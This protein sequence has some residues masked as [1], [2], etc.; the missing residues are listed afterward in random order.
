M[1]TDQ[2]DRSR[3]PDEGSA[4]VSWWA[5]AALCLGELLVVLDGTV[6]VVA[7]PSMGAALGVSHEYLIGIVNAYTAANGGF[8]LCSGRLGDLF[9][10]R[11]LFLV[12]VALFTVASLG[13][14]LSNS[15]MV[16]IAFRIF[17][18]LAGAAVTTATYSSAIAFFPE[19]S[20]RARALG[21]IS[22]I[23]AMGGIFGS[24]VGGVL[25][26]SLGWRSVFLINVPLGLAVYVLCSLLIR[27]SATI[28]S[29][30]PLDFPGAI[31]I[32]LSM[33]ST[34]LSIQQIGQEGWASGKAAVY[35]GLVAVLIL[36]C[37]LV[38][39][40]AS[41]PLIR[42]EGLRIRSFILCSI[43]SVL[44]SPIGACGVFASMYLQLTQHY[45][46][47]QVAMA[48][49]PSGAIGAVFVLV[50]SPRIVTRFG[51]KGPLALGLAAAS[52]GLAVL[53]HTA[54][55]GAGL[56]EVLVGLAIIMV[57]VG[58]S[59]TPTLVTAMSEVRPA[60]V[61]LATGMV[62]TATLMSSAV[63]L[64]AL[65]AVLTS[66]QRHLVAVGTAPT[67]AANRAYQLVFLISIVLN[68]MAIPFALALRRPR[69]L[70]V[71]VN[72]S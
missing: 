48:F 17:Q 43:I 22:A 49:L 6:V 55:V 47:I 40:K 9:G 46:P 12:G 23:A 19:V 18:G 66:Y 42:L 62:A 38:E 57:G 34:V 68:T 7:L 5:F 10:Y 45:T 33:I 71:A 24:L 41:A 29:S 37:I 54:A 16:L 1:L 30:G 11:R 14:A 26:E 21:V 8:L 13:C 2:Q 65:G 20:T 27:K 52:A 72:H 61:G 64:A 51:T 60:E 15:Y 44:C 67:A 58:I 36:A 59:S 25:T 53:V 35:L 31:L 70:S 69:D 32:T 56:Y 28:S 39:E 4:H 50:V 63:A 3:A